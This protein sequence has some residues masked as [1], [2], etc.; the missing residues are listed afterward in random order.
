MLIENAF[1]YLPE[2]LC[3]SNYEVQEYESG[4]TNAVSLALLQE[5]NARNVPN[6]LSALTVEKLYSADGYPHPDG[7]SPNRHDRVD[8]Y[9]DTSAMYVANKLL[10]RFG[11]RHRNYV[12]A[13]FFRSTIKNSTN[14]SADLLADLIRLCS[15]VP[16]QIHGWEIYS[17]ML[18]AKG[19]KKQKIWV[20][21]EGKTSPNKEYKN[22]CVG[23]YLLH[24]YLGNP[25]D[26]L[27]QG[28]RAWTIPI[29]TAGPQTL[30]IKVGMQELV[31][32]TA[33]STGYVKRFG[34]ELKDLVL[35]AQITNRV[36]QQEV[37]GAKDSYLCVLT[38]L[39]SFTLTHDTHQWS[40]TIDRTGTESNAGDWL[41]LNKL[42]G[43][44]LNFELKAEK[45]KAK[46]D[47]L[48]EPDPTME[49]EAPPP[50]NNELLIYSIGPT[51]GSYGGYSPFSPFS[52]G[53][54]T[55]Q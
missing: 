36:I 21:F 51:S 50:S 23:R 54:D 14:N 24:V 3:G 20:P 22:L 32:G 2:I 6:P 29:R 26:Y 35:K 45:Q 27:G 42:V 46:T 15:L 31:N 17:K 7:K 25:E 34:V 33:E 52:L 48:P 1:T 13:K 5:L 49:P 12:E 55:N 18:K 8:L 39:D 10:S 16:P 53:S 47:K 43:S 40:E 37:A 11:W 9:F 30:D 4:I 28:S 38:R 44:Y 41:K 19:W